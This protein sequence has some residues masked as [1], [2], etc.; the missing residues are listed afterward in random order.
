MVPILYSS[1][2]EGTVPSHYGVGALTDCLA[3][4]VNEERNGAFELR[5][6]YAA[7]GIHANEIEVGRYIKA[8][9]NF[10][11]NPQLFR[12]YQVG[13]ELNGRFEVRAEHVVYTLSG[14]PIT[15]GTANNCASACALLTASAGSFTINTTKT[16]A[17]NF[18]ITAPS[19]VRSWFG[20]K[21]GSLLDVYGGGEWHYDNFTATLKEH[22]GVTT[23]V[24]TIRYKK[25][26]TEFNQE[27][28][29]SNL[30]THVLCYYQP[31]DGA[32]VLGSEVATGLSGTKRVLILDVTSD[33]NEA[34]EVSDLDD[35]ATAYIGSHNLTTPETNFTLNFV[36]SGQ[37]FD[38]VDLCDMV[39]VY[40]EP[41]GITAT[42][43]CIRVLWDV[44]K[45]R[46]IETE[47]G[48]PKVNIADTIADTNKAATEAE[49]NASQAIGLANSKRRVFV[50][51][52]VPPYDVGDIWTDSND[53]Y[54]CSNPRTETVIEEASGAVA[55]FDT[56]INA[57]LLNCEAGI[58][59]T[60]DLNGYSKPW[61]G[62][63][64][65]NL[66][67]ETISDAN[68]DGTGTIVA[69]V[70]F[71]DLQAA[72]VTS[73]ET[74]TIKTDAGQFIGGFFTSEPAIGS[75]TYDGQRIVQN[76]QTFTA[77]T[78]GFVVFRTT[79]GYS[80]PQLEV[81]ST[82][83]TWEP[84]ANDCPLT[85]YTEANVTRA[86]K[87]LAKFVSND[88]VDASGNFVHANSNGLCPLYPLKNG[89][90][91]TIT[92]GSF[93]SF[94]YCVMSGGSVLYR[95]GSSGSD[96]ETYTAAQDCS[97]YVW[98]NLGSGTN[99]QEYFD[100]NECQLEFGDTATAFEPY[101]GETYNVSFG[102]AGTVYKGT[103]NVTTGEL[104]VTHAIVDLGELTQ[105]S[106]ASTATYFF[107]YGLPN[108]KIVPNGSVA[109][110]T[111]EQYVATSANNVVTQYT[112]L[113]GVIA[114]RNDGVIMI[115]DLGKTDLTNAQFLAAMAGIKLAYELATPAT[116][117][118][119]AQE[120]T[121]LIGTNNVW[122]DTNG[123]TSVR[124]YK[125]G[126]TMSDWELA[127]DYVGISTL[128]TAIAEA[129]DVITGT[130]GGFVVW[131]DSDNDGQPD[132]I[133]IMDTANI[134]TA[135]KVWRWNAGGLGFSPNGYAGPYDVTAINANGQLVADA[136]TT[137][138]LDASRVTIQHLTATMFE[139]GKLT[140]GGMNNQA[141]VFE[142][143]NAQG[144][145]IGEMNKDGLK[146]YGD[147]PEGSRPYVV[148]NNTDGL[149]G[150]DAN[151]TAIFWVNRDEFTMKKCVAQ[152]EINACNKIKF[153]PVTIRDGN[154]D[155]VN[156]GVAIVG[157]VQN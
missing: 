82:S 152:N 68:I 148:L 146:F 94:G 78:T 129:S 26:L 87:N 39:N 4:E 32:K 84:Y 147:G 25:N 101:E 88:Y 9:P 66:V 59:G 135:T 76:N 139:G 119:T 11:D 45:N 77:P 142:L 27:I 58:V 141:G 50:S 57:S 130:A 80:T 2:T 125:D 138:S 8:K 149:K 126:F 3:C 6:V 13:K 24:A 61:A 145:V 18:A 97:I 29:C 60:Q 34:P 123:N 133:L 48:S 49:A 70:G 14:K 42:V 33:F 56:L 99:S 31:T 154:N 72:K 153:V 73:G 107:G 20:G 75:V 128:E 44:L 124:Y 30:Y 19:S 144:V 1:I 62:G 5:L 81:G 98:F 40:F 89:Q 67:Y 47:F 118:L 143:L 10:T 137:G 140:L 51:T 85:A 17:G 108:P 111:C 117:Q 16:T 28:N 74:Y 36:Q 132:E 12:I 156:D 53:I 120:I 150:Y 7:M 41:L 115:N 100:A 65:K 134:D 106:K 35:K 104:T 151:D 122:N 86:G 63:C 79:H 92:K 91:V 113:N 110:F 69:A 121:Q 131:H 93:L 103:L 157:I 90:S 105:Y 21:E 83:T 112:T 102:A 96:T 109:D 136:I 55:N 114:L 23:P 54:Y 64:G 127:T 71:S 22:R 95:K 15:S 37:L 43:K 38:R 52:P 155:I 116:Y 46:Y